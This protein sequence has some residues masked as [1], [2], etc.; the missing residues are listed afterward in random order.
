[1]TTAS[2]AR[3][4]A[5]TQPLRPHRPTRHRRR[6]PQALQLR[7]EW[8][9]RRTI[10]GLLGN[11]AENY[12]MHLTLW[13]ML[14]GFLGFALAL[15]KYDLMY[16]AAA[17]TG[18]FRRRPVE[19]IEP[20][21]SRPALPAPPPAPAAPV[22]DPLADP[23][24]GIGVPQLAAPGDERPPERTDRIAVVRRGPTDLQTSRAA[25]ERNREIAA[26]ERA[27]DQR[28]RVIFR[29]TAEYREVSEKLK[30][31]EER[32][33]T[34]ELDLAEATHAE[35]A[36]RRALDEHLPAPDAGRLAALLQDVWLANPASRG[37]DD[38][39]R[40]R[41]IAQAAIDAVRG[42]WPIDR[43]PLAEIEQ[44]HPAG[45]GRPLTSPGGGAEAAG[46]LP[47]A[48]PPAP[49]D[50]TALGAVDEQHLEA[51]ARLAACRTFV[52]REESWD[53]LDDVMRDHWRHVAADIMRAG[54]RPPSAELAPRDRRAAVAR[55]VTAHEQLT[56]GTC[57][58]GWGCLENC[59]ALGCD[60]HPVWH[61]EHLAAQLLALGVT[62]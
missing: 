29:G 4:I 47:T 12:L 11:A 42:M 26:L 9:P 59:D 55:V 20:P 48:A 50:S 25:A 6:S 43:W 18:F 15:D 54:W 56:D 44:N 53:D 24:D 1:M 46:P 23:D 21:A 32:A 49:G 5:A 41:R 19:E 33:R 51:L 40:W 39:I 17:L 3:P 34:A 35:A 62:R 36:L 7:H 31:A 22:E 57:R 16:S 37:V 30:V 14:I 10:G 27:I 28:D 60:G 45:T 61:A 58:C 2:I 52:I 38:D 13:A 8:K